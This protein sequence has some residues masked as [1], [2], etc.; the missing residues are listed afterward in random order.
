VD[1]FPLPSSP[2]YN[3]LVLIP[4]AI[5]GLRLATFLF[6]LYAAVWIALEGNLAQ[7]VLLAFWAALIAAGRLFGRYLAGRHLSV[8]LWLLVMVAAGLAVGLGSA[9]LTLFFMVIKTGLH[10]HGPE[11]S[12]AE[13]A[14]LLRQL[15]LWSLAGLLAGLGIALLALVRSPAGR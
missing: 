15:P 7:T 14:W 12:P 9:L 13:I 1:Y 6:A 10:A 3:P 2:G 4:T 8:P 5:P 11:F